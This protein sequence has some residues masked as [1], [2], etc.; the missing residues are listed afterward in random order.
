MREQEHMSQD[1]LKKLR[2]FSYIKMVAMMG[3]IAAVIAFSSIAW[4]TMNREVEGEGVQMTASDLPFEVKVSAPYENSPDYSLLLN[5]Q[6]SYDTTHHETGG[7]VG[8]IKC[9]MVDATAD[10]TNPMRGLQP[11]SHGTITF[12]IK[13]KATGTYTLHFDIAT[14]GYHAEFNVDGAGALQPDSIK[15]K[16]VDDEEVPIFYSL[17]DYAEMQAET[18]SELYKSSLYP[19]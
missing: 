15:T 14:T 8:G 4:F 3:I 5:S 11:G 9:L 16:T 2:R 17:A 12:Q 7:S 19:P 6:L 18:V 10:P 1:E 13:P